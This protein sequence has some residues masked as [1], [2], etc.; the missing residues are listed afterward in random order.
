MP[1]LE[2]IARVGDSFVVVVYS[3]ETGY[4]KR[5]HEEGKGDRIGGSNSSGLRLCCICLGVVGALLFRHFHKRNE[6]EDQPHLV[7]VNR[8]CRA[9]ESVR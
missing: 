8:R 2:I 9:R 7:A 3:K 6:K 1:L 5:D 4:K